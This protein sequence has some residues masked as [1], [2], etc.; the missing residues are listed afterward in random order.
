M[1]K[2]LVNPAGVKAAPDPQVWLDLDR[3]AEAELPSEDPESPI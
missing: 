3:L 2:R 1:R